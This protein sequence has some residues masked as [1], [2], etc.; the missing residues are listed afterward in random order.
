[1]FFSG[2]GFQPQAPQKVWVHFEPMD[3]NWILSAFH[4]QS[5]L[6]AYFSLPCRHTH[7]KASFFLP[8]FYHNKKK[9]DA[10][11]PPSRMLQ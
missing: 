8:V 1:M 2:A 4:G 7:P 6:E 11:A 3:V 5:F 10:K 9:N